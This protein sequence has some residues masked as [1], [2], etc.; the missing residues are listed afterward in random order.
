MIPKWIASFFEGQEVTL[1]AEERLQRWNDWVLPIHPDEPIG[2]DITY[3]DDFETIKT[4]LGK[5]SG[6]DTALIMRASERL[7]KNSAKDLRVAAYY[8]YASLRQRGAV[9]FSD[10]LELICSLLKFYPQDIWPK[11]S[12]QRRSALEWLATDKVID[13][14]VTG[15]LSQHKDLKQIL[16]AL[17]LLQISLLEWDEE[18]IPNLLPLFQQLEIALTAQKKPMPQLVEAANTIVSVETNQGTTQSINVQTPDASISSSKMLLDQTRIM[19][20]YL[21]Q[22]ENGYWA[23]YK[24][25]RAIR[26]GMIHSV[27]PSVDGKTRLK[28][29][30]VDLQASLKRLVSEKKWLD[31][32][33][34]VDIAFLEGANQYWLD[35]QYYAWLGQK[36]LGERYTDQIDS[37]L[38]ELK[39]L[40]MRYPELL[41]LSFDGGIPF[42][43]DSVAEWL[44][45]QVLLESSD[46]TEKQIGTASSQVES[47]FEEERTVIEREVWHLFDEKGFE[48]AIDWLDINPYLQKGKL[49]C[50]KLV[51]MAKLADKQQKN[52]LAV[53][54]LE[55]AIESMEKSNVISWDTD[56]SFE[57]HAM[58]YR[59][60]FSKSKR[61]DLQFEIEKIQIQI[62]VLKNRLMQIDTVRALYLLH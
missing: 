40:I 21:R 62:E 35:L 38:C 58:L 4:E 13:A 36:S 3:E 56:F 6:T 55:Q 48:A 60:V 24:M 19:A 8:A 25:I 16:S 49:A 30:R 46:Y 22:Q 61:K 14:L 44:Q 54:L 37:T 27:P 20:A 53:S 32:L 33:E 2:Y 9:G 42:V 17:I 47:R 39:S 29:P 18:N 43:S 59:L 28:P 11:R 51:L 12:T 15:D 5:L 34:L 31:L 41:E 26:W 45:N 57:V 1:I 7:L 50:Y 52:D 10:G 23:A